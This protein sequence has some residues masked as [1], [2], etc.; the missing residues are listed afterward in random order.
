ML[1]ERKAAV[2]KKRKAV[3]FDLDGTLWDSSRQITE[4]W[5]PV[6]RE[7]GAEITVEEMQGFMGKTLQVIG[8]MIF[9]EKTEAEVMNIMRQCSRREHPY[10]RQHGGRLYPYLEQVLE[11]LSHDYF[12]SIVSNCQDGYIQAF[13]DHYGFWKYFDDIEMAGRTGKTKGENIAL[14]MKRNGIR[15]AVYVGDT[16]GDREAAERAGVPFIYASYGFGQVEPGR[17]AWVLQMLADLPKVAA[18]LLT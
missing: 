2:L 6:L 8:S 11:N 3:I 1:E 7:Y 14:V 4:A 17:P 15:H 16:D 10:V 18:R 13:L 5:N 9:P 12:L